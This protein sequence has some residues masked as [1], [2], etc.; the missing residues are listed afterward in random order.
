MTTITI[1]PAM[2]KWCR[3]L[4]N[5]DYYM[6]T[7]RRENDIG[8]SGSGALSIGSPNYI[9]VEKMVDAG[10]VE[11][12]RRAFE[13]NQIHPFRARLTPAGLQIATRKK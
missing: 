4:N 3:A 2:R 7:K 11:W 10:L 12:R 6:W 5:G 9:I 8:A 13:P 1:T